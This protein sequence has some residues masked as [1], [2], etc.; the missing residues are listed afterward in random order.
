[1][2]A[3]LVRSIAAAG[4]VLWLA[5]GGALAQGQFSAL[6]RADGAA[7]RLWAEDGGLA[8]DLAL[9]HPVPW[10][11]RFLNAPPR[12]IVDFREVDFRALDG[13]RL[14]GAVRG[15][16]TDLRAGPVREGWSRLVLALDRPQLV[17]EAEMRTALRGGDGALLRLRLRPADPAAFAA[18]VARPDPPGWALPKPAMT[19][20]PRK[21]RGQG[22]LVVVLDPGH[23]GLDP[24]AE[25][26]GQSEARLMLTFARELK[27]ALVRAGIARVVMTRE[28]DS[29]VPLETRVAI[30]HQA[31]ADVF[32]SLHADAVPEGVATG[33]TVYTLAEAASDAASAAL[34]ERH[35]RDALMAGVD[36]TGQDD[37]I[38]GVLM[39]MARRE[40]APRTEKLA[41]A[42]VA[43][44]AAA[45]LPLHKVPRR[46]AAFS[47]LKAPDIPSVLVEL[48]YISSPRDLAR[49]SDPAWRATMAG[50]IVAGL[51]SWSVEDAAA[52]GLL[53]Q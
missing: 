49:L 53:R 39:D 35:D 2:I 17:S 51:S 44:M 31:G 21:P 30:A 41:D 18:E 16:V 47:V 7:S 48:G 29:F 40:T 28:D 36:L 42:L 45:R 13:A 32:L 6:A 52:A 4:V 23:G 15:K 20:A 27:E 26:D 50:A 5:A 22:P 24:G 9:S 12:L 38:A 11:V 25:H 10:R 37:L 43:A 34:A 3:T 19:P 46:G 1:M 14:M 33:A 8:L